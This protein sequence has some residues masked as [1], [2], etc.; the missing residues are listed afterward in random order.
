MYDVMVAAGQMEF[1]A[2]LV[3][4]MKGNSIPMGPGA[5]NFSIRE[6][7]GVVALAQGGDELPDH[8]LVRFAHDGFLVACKKRFAYLPFFAEKRQD[9]LT[10]ADR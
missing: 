2:G 6:P 3:T 8:G 10:Q 5:V 1:F 9:R 4:E 7:R